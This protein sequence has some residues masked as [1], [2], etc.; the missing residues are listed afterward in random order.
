MMKGEP[1]DPMKAVMSGGS[2][3]A[4]GHRGD[5]DLS[6]RRVLTR[7]APRVLSETQITQ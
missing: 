6:H 5:F 2:P 1:G 3:R 7:E 4:F